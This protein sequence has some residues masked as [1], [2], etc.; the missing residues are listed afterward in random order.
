MLDQ[1]FDRLTIQVSSRFDRRHGLKLFWLTAVSILHMV[2]E[3]VSGRARTPSRHGTFG[4][5][6][7]DASSLPQ[8]YE[9]RK[10]KK[11]GGGETCEVGDDVCENL[12]VGQDSCC[13]LCEPNQYCEDGACHSLEIDQLDLDTCLNVVNK[14]ASET[15]TAC[16]SSCL[17]S[18]SQQCTEC[19]VDWLIGQDLSLSYCYAMGG[20]TAASRST[21]APRSQDGPSFGACQYSNLN[22]CNRRA[23]DEL[24]ADVRRRIEKAAKKYIQDCFKRKKKRC[25]DIRYAFLKT[26]LSTAAGVGLTF[27][28]K[29]S[30]CRGL[31]GCQWNNPLFRPM[32]CM[33]NDQCC[34]DG[35]IWNPGGGNVQ[36]SCCWDEGATCPWVSGL[37]TRCC[38]TLP[39]GEYRTCSWH[40]GSL[41][42]GARCIDC[43]VTQQSSSRATGDQCPVPPSCPSPS[44]ICSNGACCPPDTCPTDPSYDGCLVSGN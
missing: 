27:S 36:G 14:N 22:V 23:Y 38:G 16:R 8:V 12:C 18:E 26:F 13:P 21:D 33:P 10:K 17:D 34:I 30:V 9:V 42:E 37:Y 19:I 5:Q 39:S 2:S 43:T 20:S 11:K 1:R 3:P 24:P 44:S 41:T 29:L 4:H 35:Q 6:Y 31:Y 32:T 28:R 15:A 25:P 40:G 7:S